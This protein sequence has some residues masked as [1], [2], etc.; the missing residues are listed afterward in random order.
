MPK[1]SQNI[2]DLLRAYKEREGLSNVAAV[3]RA[4]DVPETRL[5]NWMKKTPCRQ[6]YLDQIVQKL[7]GSL[8]IAERRYL[9]KP[10]VHVFSSLMRESE[11]V[12]L[13]HFYGAATVDETRI[14]I[15]TYPKPDER[16]RKDLN[17]TIHRRM[18][19]T[20]DLAIRK[21]EQINCVE[22]A[23]DLAH[24]IRTFGT[25]HYEIRVYSYASRI[26]YLNFAIFDKRSVIAGGYHKQ[27]RPD[28]EP[29]M[30]CFDQPFVGLY[31]K[32]WE[33]VWNEAEPL[34][35]SRKEKWEDV[36]LEHVKKIP[37]NG[38][39]SSND[40]EAMVA[41][42]AEDAKKYPARY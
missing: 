31:R 28:E 29:F 23:V 18:T 4:L 41:Q 11:E 26:P 2:S 24:N 16:Y 5:A 13:S 8:E 25:E 3:A 12:F 34:S 37:G 32:L 14:G 15:E 21:V 40:F 9:P 38:N 6:P 7:G 35:H 10:G 17:T 19:E 22:R 27:G 30:D 42:R 36:L 20:R 33:Y 1:G 39:L